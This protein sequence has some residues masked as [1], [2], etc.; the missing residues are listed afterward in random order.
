MVVSDEVWLLVVCLG[1]S[2]EGGFSVV[3][4]DVLGDGCDY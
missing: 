4:N 1:V 2:G 3:L